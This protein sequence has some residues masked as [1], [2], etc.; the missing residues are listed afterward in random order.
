M[1]FIAYILIS[2][3]VSG[4]AATPS[5]TLDI[6][7]YE[8]YLVPNDQGQSRAKLFVILNDE[9]TPYAKIRITNFK[10]GQMQNLYITSKD[11][12]DL[13]SA[14]QVIADSSPGDGAR[15]KYNLKANGDSLSIYTVK[16]T[17][18]FAMSTN[19]VYWI[20]NIS[21]AKNILST[22]EELEKASKVD[23]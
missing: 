13:R 16:D 12:P 4:C 8:E 14:L 7:I 5:R 23:K 19:H 11:I 10:I 9:G 17:P 2:I 6:D 21:E 18:Q 3:L 22:L 15:I 20:F 1:K